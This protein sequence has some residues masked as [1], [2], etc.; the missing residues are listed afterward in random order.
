MTVYYEFDVSL[1]DVTP[2]VWRRF[3]MRSTA[4][5]LDLHRAIQDACGWEDG[6]LFAFRTGDGRSIAGVPDAEFSEPDPDAAGVAL[7]SHFA[8]EGD[9]CL[10]EYDFGDSWMHEVLLGGIVELSD[11]FERRL[12]DGARAFPPEDCGGLPGYEDCVRVARGGADPD[13]LAEWLGDWDPDR[14]AL[15]TRRRSFDS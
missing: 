8:Q 1:H 14:F 3:Q 9:H 13:E 5:F 2:R 15:T 10:Y 11:R 12:L 7:T 4:T 6:H